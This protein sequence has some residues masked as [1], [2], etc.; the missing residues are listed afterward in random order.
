MRFLAKYVIKQPKP[1]RWTGFILVIIGTTV[2]IQWYV[3]RS[4]SLIHL[5]LIVQLEYIQQNLERRLHIQMLLNRK[6]IDISAEFNDMLTNQQQYIAIQNVTDKRLRLRLIDL[7]DEV[8]ELNKELI[9]YQVI[10]KGNSSS[11]LRVHEFQLY[12][13]N[14]TSGDYRYRIV[15]TRGN[16][17]IKSLAGTIIV[18]IHAKYNGKNQKI[19]VGKHP[20]NLRHVQVIKGQIKIANNIKPKKITIIIKQKK[21]PNILEIFD[22]NIGDKH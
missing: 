10:T 9:F 8:I 6:L 21:Q 14:H 15:I 3:D 17:I 7:Q 13:Y 20:L 5:K 19:L 22:W 16:E 1:L 12:A 11:K 2:A 4:D 18:G